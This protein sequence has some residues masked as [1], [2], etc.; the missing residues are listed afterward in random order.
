MVWKYKLS[1]VMKEI[2]HAFSSSRPELFPQK[3]VLI[4]FEKIYIWDTSAMACK[5]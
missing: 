1:H 4:N 2:A 3:A 5:S